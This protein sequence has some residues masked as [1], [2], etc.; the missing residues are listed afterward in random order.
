MLTFGVACA[1]L[2]EY[3]NVGDPKPWHERH[4]AL[5]L[6]DIRRVVRWAPTR[7]KFAGLCGCALALITGFVFGAVQLSSSYAATP[8]D[9]VAMSFYVTSFH[10]LALPVVSS[11]AR[12]PYSYETQFMDLDA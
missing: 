9:L 8:E 6:R 4:S 7:H 2:G 5:K 11:A 3:A 10:L 12:M 1:L